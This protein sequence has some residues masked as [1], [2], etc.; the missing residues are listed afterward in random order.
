MILNL[1]DSV[2]LKQS[3][4]KRLKYVT[5]YYYPT[6]DPLHAICSWLGVGVSF[7]VLEEYIFNG[8]I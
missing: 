6:H 2:R 3:V 7:V 4:S 1:Q 8:D 5:D